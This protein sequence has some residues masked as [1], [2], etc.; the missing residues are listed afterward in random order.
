MGPLDLLNHLLNFAAP[1]LAVG[2]VLAFLAP[3][4]MKNKALDRTR[5]AQVAINFVVGLLALL[6]GLLFFG[7]D[8]KM[9]SYAALVLA[10]AASQWWAMRR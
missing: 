8:G 9:A 4:F 2:L 3:V 6:A 7:R 5:T 10:T 1:A